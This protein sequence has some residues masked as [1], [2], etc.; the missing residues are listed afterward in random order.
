MRSL[1]AVAYA[2]RALRG[3]LSLHLPVSAEVRRDFRLDLI[4]SILFGIFNG[5]VISYLYVVGRTI[6]VSTLGISVMVAMPAVG[7]V[8]ALP[9][10]MLIRGPAGRP[11]MIGSWTIGRGIILLTLVFQNPGAYMA[12]ASLFLISTSIAAPFY[13]AVMQRV[14]PMEYRGRLM[15]LVRIGGGTATT[16]TSLAVAW[17]LGSGRVHFSIVFAVA[18]IMALISLAVFARVTPVRPQQRARQ[19][20]K[21]IFAIVGR[22]QGFKRSQI[23]T[24]LMAFGN[25][26]SATLY[27]LLI[28]DK[29]HAGYGA[30]GILSFCSSLGYLISFFVWGR[31]LDRKGGLFGMYLVGVTV[32]IQQVGLIIAPSAYWLIP[33]ALVMGVTAA[34]FELGPYAVITHFARSTPQDVPSYM[35]LYS[36]FAGIRGL[37]AP[38]LAT[39]LL[40][41]LHYTLSLSCALAITAIGTLLLWQCFRTEREEQVVPAVAAG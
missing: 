33:F 16:L 25:I 17:L 23:A 14:Y 28:V 7:A 40:G 2:M 19:S 15:S 29:L 5:S 12:I 32:A 39:G 27:P 41:V 21:E 8:L 11:F 34:G 22:D 9:A 36:Y 38:F 35:G 4:G 31:I 30:Y 1:A 37:T 24:F 26:I 18:T 10:S 20:F 6:G 3:S 13:A